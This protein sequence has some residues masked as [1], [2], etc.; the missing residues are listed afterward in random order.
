M[1]RRW[2]VAL[3]VVT[4]AAA[5]LVPTAH[6]ITR[7]EDTGVA[8]GPNLPRP[9]V[10]GPPRQSPPNSFFPNYNGQGYSIYVC[11]AARDAG[12]T[13][14][15][16]NEAMDFSSNLDAIP[17]NGMGVRLGG[18]AR[19][20]PNAAAGSQQIHASDTCDNWKSGADG[21]L[22][23]RRLPGQGF[24]FT[25]TSPGNRGGGIHLQFGLGV[26]GALSI[27][28]VDYDVD[29]AGFK[30]K[31]NMGDGDLP[32]VVMD[33]GFGVSRQV[34]P[35]DFL[36]ASAM[37][38]LDTFTELRACSN[39]G[40]W[41][42]TRR[43]IS[44]T[45]PVA[46]GWSDGDLRYDQD[47]SESPRSVNP[48]GAIFVHPYYG[49]GPSARSTVWWPYMFTGV[50]GHGAPNS[51]CNVSGGPS[52]NYFRSQGGANY[53]RLVLACATPV[54]S[55]YGC[56]GE[57]GTSAEP[58]SSRPHTPRS[59]VYMRSLRVFVNDPNDPTVGMQPGGMNANGA[60]I[61]SGNDNR[62]EEVLRFSPVDQTGIR[63]IQVRLDGVLKQDWDFNSNCDHR[64]RTPCPW[65]SVGGNPPNPGA[66]PTEWRF[67][68]DPLV[69]GMHA[70]EVSVQDGSGRWSSQT[71]RFN[72]DTARREEVCNDGGAA[73]IGGV[74]SEVTRTG[75]YGTDLVTAQPE[76]CRGRVYADATPLAPAESP[77]T[78]GALV[79]LPAPG[80]A[81]FSYT[82]AA[83]QRPASVPLNPGDCMVRDQ[84]ISGA[85]GG[86]LGDRER[87]QIVS[88]T[89]DLRSFV[90]ESAANG[91][92]GAL[93]EHVLKSTFDLPTRSTKRYRTALGC[94]S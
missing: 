18:G 8:F 37:P 19:A 66:V 26:Y 12:Y 63:R 39:H 30:S 9:A 35:S 75:V 68:V 87:N 43:S 15:R 48:L 28:H 41:N 38:D 77:L 76:V 93:G 80:Q 73:P 88:V 86:P 56:R 6:G 49:A 5:Y 4:I 42:V 13:T 34:A 25:D 29:V 14:G 90:K 11:K 57:T 44:G 69:R 94:P 47:Q 24:M 7:P 72:I 74:S 17:N 1:R 61:G 31:G 55:Y 89:I 52:A 64:Y 3:V 23:L 20:F 36:P 45:Y 91:A 62:T 40:R 85:S 92:G 53:L 21:G 65:A 50:G 46:Q 22:Q 51:Q 16:L 71:A 27:A 54:N 10:P 82:L 32:V 84:V 78:R 70:A 83:N 67:D 60:T 59:F 33:Q 79:A 58:A 2:W 81:V